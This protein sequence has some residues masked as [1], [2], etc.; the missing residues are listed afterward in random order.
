MS[1]SVKVLF[2]FAALSAVSHLAYPQAVPGVKSRSIL[3]SV[4]DSHGNAVRNLNEKEFRVRIGGKPTPVLK[5]S[6]SL[7]PRRIVVMLDMSG[8]MTAGSEANKKWRIAREALED[9][10]AETP[11]DVPIALLTFSDRVNDVFDFSQGRSSIAAWLKQGPSQRENI[12][13]R[14][15]LRD[16][17]VAA[18]R[19][20]QPTRQGDAIY[21]IT[22]GGDNCS[23]ASGRAVKKLLADSGVRLFA[24]L[25]NEH[26][27]I[28]EEVSGRD[29]LLELVRDSGGFVFGVTS[30]GGSVG[31]ATSTP[32]DFEYDYSQHTRD[33]IKSYA[34]ALNIQINGFY[35][36][37]V[38]V[39]S[40]RKDRTVK[41]EILDDAGRTKK[42]VAFTY[43]D[44]LPAAKPE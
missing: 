30:R 32:W 39:D 29:E 22:D 14:T 4:V 41:L 25:F 9:L 44:I 5:A 23:S 7:A 19:T 11:Q 18:V 15:A 21:V 43:Q 37:D 38:N 13:G 31:M 3:V 40:S 35:T 17:I 2:L 1:Y 20:L 16:T 26:T 36:L 6:Y 12:K 8:S 34:Q 27:P 33:L 42:D 10:L 24:F 28:A